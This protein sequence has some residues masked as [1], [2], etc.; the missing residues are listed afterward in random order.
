MFIVLSLYL[1]S[2]RRPFTEICVKTANL[3]AIQ[4]QIQAKMGS[5]PTAPSKQSRLKTE[6]WSL[7]ILRTEHPVSRIKFRETCK[8]FRGTQR[9]ISRKKWKLL[10]EK[11]TTSFKPTKGSLNFAFH[12]VAIVLTLVLVYDSLNEMSK[13][14]PWQTDKQVVVIGLSIHRHKG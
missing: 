3:S 11:A 14:L 6:S 9:K 1:L 8:L 7:I 12:A 4:T 5:M 13:S 10:E 2:K